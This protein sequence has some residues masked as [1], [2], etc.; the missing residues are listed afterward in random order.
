MSILVLDY[1]RGNLRSVAKALEKTGATVCVSADPVA[2][3]A[4]DRLV[5]PGVGAFGDCMERLREDGLDQAILRYLETERPFLGVCLGLQVLFE[6][7]EEAPDVA[8]LGVF[9]G[10]VKKFVPSSPA[11]KVPHMGWNELDYADPQVV[12]PLL[13]GIANHAAVYFVHSYYACPEDE[14]I[15]LA[16][17]TYEKPFCAAVLKGAIAAVQ[18]HPEKSHDVGLQLLK[19]FVTWKPS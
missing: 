16:R 7:S 18:F 11:Y 15:V 9:R 1:G 17:A 10:R 19:N 4:A 5:V 6:A 12:H 8:G 14:S 3:R 13:S 2:I